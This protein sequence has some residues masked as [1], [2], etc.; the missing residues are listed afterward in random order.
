MKLGVSLPDDLVAFADEEA[1]RRGT[2]RSAYLAELLEA[3]RLREQVSR[4]IDRHGWVTTCP[5]VKDADRH[6]L[7]R[8]EADGL[9]AILAA[10]RR[11]Q[12]ALESGDIPI[13]CR[14]CAIADAVARPLATREACG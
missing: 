14:G 10:R 1:R 6:A 11:I 13:A 9:E 3:E 7:G 4:Y 8:L 12:S 2:S 5:H